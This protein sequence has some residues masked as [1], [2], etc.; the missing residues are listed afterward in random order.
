MYSTPFRR[1]EETARP[2]A[3]ALDLPLNT[4][5]A[6]DTEAIMEKIVKDHKGKII[7]VVGHSNTLPAL[8]GNMGASKR[9]PPIAE[10]EYDNIYIVSIPWF[11]LRR[12]VRTV[13]A[14]S[15]IH[16]DTRGRGTYDVTSDVQAL[17]RESGVRTG[18]C[19]LFIRHTSASMMLCEN[20]DPAVRRDL[21]TFMARQVP[22]GDPM[23]THTAE[24]AADD[25]YLARGRVSTCG[26]IARLRTHAA[27]S[28][29][30]RGSRRSPADCDQ[31]ALPAVSRRMMAFSM[32]S[33]CR[34]MRTSAMTAS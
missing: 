17:V 13:I 24:G 4:Y 34:P 33:W 11:A 10:N 20:A 27:S 26:S 2:I 31:W 18:L 1:T 15:E 30:Y 25:V 5:D 16:I 29:R 22:D 12:T 28:S 23:F 21:E 32:N 8:M 14:Q 7:L 3:E 6:A 19:H 9:V